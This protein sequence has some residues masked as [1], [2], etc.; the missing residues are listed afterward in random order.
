MADLTP[1]T[2][3]ADVIEDCRATLAAATVDGTAIFPGGVAVYD[4]LASFHRVA[5]PAK[6]AVA[7]IIAGQLE[8]GPPQ[9]NGDQYTV[10]L[11]MDV[12]VRFALMRKAGSAEQSAVAEMARLACLVR[13]ALAADRTRGGRTGAIVWGGGVLL[14]TDLIGQPKL[15][16]PRPNQ[17][18]YACTIPV[19]CGW[20]V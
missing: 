1:D 6:G 15:V 16:A 4:D 14:A 3:A 19:A 17:A 10:R 9:D 11:S 2:K 7:G 13:Q 12:A 20:A 18:F 5:D 8:Q